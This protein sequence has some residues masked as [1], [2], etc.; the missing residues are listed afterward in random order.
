MI[1]I[2]IT[3][4]ICLFL[5]VFGLITNLAIYVFKIKS[6][7]YIVLNSNIENCSFELALV[8]IHSIFAKLTAV[9]GALNEKRLY[10]HCMS[11]N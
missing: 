8:F 11:G 5:V 7:L 10:S 3:A 2:Q 9:K 1:R 4:I 6:L